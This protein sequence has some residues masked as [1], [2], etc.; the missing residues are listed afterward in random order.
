MTPARYQALLTAGVL[1]GSKL[2]AARA[3][4][5]DIYERS[6]PAPD[7][8]PREDVVSGEVWMLMDLIMAKTPKGEAMRYARQAMRRRTK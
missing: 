7:A 6:R 3:V 4:L 2:D 1:D 8:A 5:L